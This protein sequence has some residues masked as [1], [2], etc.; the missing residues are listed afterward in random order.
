MGRIDTRSSDALCAWCAKIA[1]HEPLYAGGFG[2][3]SQVLLLRDYERI[4]GTDVNVYPLKDMG[5]LLCAVSQLSDAY[6]HARSAEY[7]DVRLGSGRGADHG[8]K[9][10]TKMVCQNCEAR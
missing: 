7:V 5:E 3:M 6:F 8:R 9:T 4:D 1:R 2:C 10:L